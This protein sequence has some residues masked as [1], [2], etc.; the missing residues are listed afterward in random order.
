MPDVKCR[1]DSNWG[2][3]LLEVLIAFTIVA[4]IASVLVG[5]I[6]LGIRSWENGHD[7]VE[8]YQHLRVFTEQI[9]EDIRSAYRT[10][11]EKVTS[12]IGESGKV[13][14]HT[15]AS[16]LRPQSDRYGIR[17]VSYY[18]GSEGRLIME[19]NY[20]FDEEVESSEALTLYEGVEKLGFRY[21]QIK[22]DSQEW[23]D[24]WDS[25]ESQGLPGAVEI[26]LSIKDKLPDGLTLPP[27][28]VP[29]SSKRTIL[30]PIARLQSGP[31]AGRSSR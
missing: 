18:V 31:R 15:A 29:I 2:F 25:K 21:F 9:I 5:I 17:R 22:K 30:I 1:E 16:G 26:T 19:E 3:T 28:I 20:P 7:R 24:E 6:R 14:F 8:K 13:T 23:V 27:V 12:F 4:M 10:D 11:S